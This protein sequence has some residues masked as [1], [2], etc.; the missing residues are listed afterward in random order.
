MSRIVFGTERGLGCCSDFSKSWIFYA[1]YLGMQVREVSTLNHTTVE[2]FD[3][4]V[5][6]WVW[7]DPLN[8]AQIVDAANRPLSLYQI[9]D[10]SLFTALRVMPLMDERPGF[11]VEGYAGYDTAET[12]VLMWRMGTNFLEIEQ[13]DSR[14]REWGLTKAARP[15]ILLTAGIQPRWLV[16][17]TL[18]LS[19]YLRALQAFIIGSVGML[20]ILHLG[21]LVSLALR[22]VRAWRR[23][24]AS[25]AAA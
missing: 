6:G 12:A 2:F 5:G 11:D 1:R 16:L 14:L 18:S 25:T 10:R 21:M 9:R 17:T 23:R 19:A 7:L 8:R 24:R 4:E 3:R 22:S 15:A 13:Q 20:V